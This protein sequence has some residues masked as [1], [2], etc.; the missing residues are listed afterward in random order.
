MDPYGILGIPKNASLEDIKKAYRR[1][2]MKWHPD[3]GN[4]STESKERFHQAADAY[5]FLSENYSRARN[6]DLGP[7]SYGSYQSKRSNS[8]QSEYSSDTQHV[9]PRSGGKENRYA[10]DTNYIYH[11]MVP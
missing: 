11:I 10:E 4:G 7:Q 8:E 2:A 1:E 3:R 5:K 6:D 9:Q